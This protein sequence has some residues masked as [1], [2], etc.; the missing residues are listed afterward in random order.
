MRFDVLLAAVW[1]GW[2][3]FPVSSDRRLFFYDRAT[4]KRFNLV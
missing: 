3:H 2:P 4:L 1:Y